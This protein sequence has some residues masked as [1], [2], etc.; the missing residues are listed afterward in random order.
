MPRLVVVSVLVS[1]SIVS[2]AG[3]AVAS[4]A[5]GHDAAAA[6]L[7]ADFNN[8]GAEDLA[9][10]VPGETVGTSFSAGAVNVL[11]GSMG[12]GL[13]GAGSEL[14]TQDSPGVGSTAEELDRF[15][16]TL[17]SSDFNNDGFS[18]LAV[19]APVETVG[20]VEGAGAVN[21]MF[22][23]A[24]GLTGAG[25]Q[26]FT[27]D[28]PGVGSSVEPTDLFGLALAAG[29]FNN[30]GTDDLAVGAAAESV[31]TVQFAGAVNVLYG[32]PVSGL[33]GAN[34][35]LFTQD[36]P[37]VGSTAEQSD[38]FGQTLAAGDF[39]N[40]GTE[41]LA[42]GAAFE[43]V[44]V[45][46][47]AGAV[48]VLYGRPVTGLT[49]ANSQLFTQDTPG[50]GSTAEEG[51]AFGLLLAGGDFDANGADDLAV[52]VPFET[53]GAVLAGGAVNVLYGSTSRLTGTGSQLF[54]QDTP[55][56]EDTVERPDLFGFALA[57][58]DFDADN[59]DDLAIGAPGE[60]LGTV[61][62]A[63]AVNVL[64]GSTNRLSGTGSQLF[65][66]DTP[67]VDDTAEEFDFFGGAL[68]ASSEEAMGGASA[69]R[70]VDRRGIVAD[71]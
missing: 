31:G 30:S 57:G 58:G 1:A 47:A 23:S 69:D 51:D 59:A 54:T 66:Q 44:G 2:P 17:A 4:P 65:T 67:G 61:L 38:Q 71:P 27:Q 16:E 11:Y 5:A 18:D 37:G 62:Q 33:T 49:G 40:S 22:G 6:Q 35:Q 64:H 10:G 42:V 53:V 29:D 48:N 50:V 9:I 43:S 55:G 8:D 26:L 3:V 28:T 46:E 15:G 41:D 32:R 13:T 14:F 7:R 24:S 68:D 20:T 56:V 60:S 63:G 19:G 45:V 34:S 52:G 25:S 70:A 12:G 21:V 39:N 36:S